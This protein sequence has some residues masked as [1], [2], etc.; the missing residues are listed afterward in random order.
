M[1]RS[2][3]ALNT[4]RG[5]RVAAMIC[6]CFFV[7]VLIATLIFPTPLGLADNHDYWRLMNPF[8]LTYPDNNIGYFYDHISL[9]FAK[10]GVW[11]WEV[12]SSGLVFV[13]L[14]YLASYVLHLSVLPLVFLGIIYCCFYTWAYFLFIRNSGIKTFLATLLFGFISLLF[15]ADI[16]FTA[17]F[18]SFYQEAAT[19]IFLLFF[20]ALFLSPK[21]HFT[22]EWLMVVGLCFSKVSNV[23]FM[24]LFVLLLIKYWYQ[25]GRL[26]KIL[27]I[28][29]AITGIA[30]VQSHNQ[31]EASSPNIFDSFFQG[32]VRDQNAEQILA[33]F[34]L[35]DPVYTT[36]IGKD[37]W[38]V[39]DFSPAIQSDFYAKVN[40]GKII[41]Y[42]LLHPPIVVEKSLQ[43]LHELIAEPRPDNLGNRAANI[44][45][46][47]IIETSITSFWQKILPYV[48]IP[49]LVLSFLQMIYIYSRQKKL[50]W[51]SKNILLMVLPVF[52]PLQLLTSFIGDGWNEFAKHNVTFYFVFVVWL[53]ISGQFWYQYWQAKKL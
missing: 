23:S 53:L 10:G 28:L 37:F 15:L 30:F 14:A 12:I 16:L 44:S 1:F 9:N 43:L 24:F 48:L 41:V 26:L 31:S 32:L 45:K 7:L 33:D 52:L 21:R 6:V 42:Y 50:G 20:V 46:S 5:L 25:A 49:G 8:G 22:W 47:M 36:Y 11:R 17:Y 51:S 40:H 39:G 19:F 13:G 35:T 38:Q 29:L 2:S 3:Q 4:T 18:N 27:L 34:Q